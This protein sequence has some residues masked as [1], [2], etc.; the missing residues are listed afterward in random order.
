MFIGIASL[1][2]DSEANAIANDAPRALGRA[3]YLYGA[4]ARWPLAAR[5]VRRRD[6]RRAA[7]FAGWSV[8]AANTSVYGGGMYIAPDAR[9]DDGLL[10]VVLTAQ[11]EPAA[12]RALDAA[13]LPGTHVERRA[14]GVLRGRE[15]RVSASRPFAVFADGDPIAELPAVRRCPPPSVL[16]PADGRCARDSRSPRHAASPAPPAPSAA[17]ARACRARC[18]C[19]GDPRAIARLAAGL[20]SGSAVISATNGKTT[21]AA[22]AAAILEARGDAL[23][24]NRAGANMAGGVADRA[25]RASAATSA[26]SR[27]TS[28]GST[29]RA[30][31]APAGAAAGN[32]FRDQLDRYGE[33]DT[34]ADRW[35]RVAASTAVAR[36]VLNADD[37]TSPTSAAPRRRAVLRRRGRRRRAGPDAAR[38]GRQALPALRRA[39]R[40]RRASTWATSAATTA[41]LRRAAAPAAIARGTSARRRPRGALRAR[42]RTEPLEVALPL[43]G[44]YNVYNALGAAALAGARRA[45]CRSSPGSRPGGAAFGRAETVRVGDRELSILLVKNPAGA[46]EV[47]RTLALEAGEH[48][49]LAVLNDNIADG[50]DVSWVWDADFEVLAPRVRRVTCSGTRAEEMALRLKYAGVPGSRI[51]VPASWA[52]GSTPRCAGPAAGASSRSRPT[53]RCSR[54]AAAACGARRA[55]S[56]A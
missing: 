21:T 18:C 43:P 41:S 22:M 20:G 46:N 36:L 39:L 53:R 1:G 28:S 23:V 24:H 4:I 30:R 31:A 3:I 6:R 17:A 54:C 27:S 38:L 10:D 52:T 44:L 8:I 26:C 49:V 48:D 9:I 32:L 7:S 5:A 12:L 25:A 37:P 2:F 29:A 42:H 33:L 45:R 19:A 16:L 11:D 40:L 35:A 34:I 50:R 47:L 13:R 15:V 56:F 14:V 55:G 51:A